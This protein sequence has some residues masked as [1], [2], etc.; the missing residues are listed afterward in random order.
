MEGYRVLGAAT[1]GQAARAMGSEAGIEARTVASLLWRIQAG[2]LRLDESSVLLLDEAGMTDD[3]AML[4]VVEEAEHAR[5]KVVVIGDHRQLSAVGLGGGLEALV[6]R[7]RAAVH[8][9][10]EN[11]RQRDVGEQTA[12][13]QLRSGDVGEAIGWY[14]ANDRVA[15]APTR[16]DALDAVIDR[17]VADVNDA[18][19]TLLLAWR[20]MDVAAL[21]TRARAAWADAGHLTGP[22][23]GAPGGRRYAVGE[24]VVALAP[25]ADGAIVT[26]ERAVI[27][28]VVDG[29][30]D[31]ETGAGRVARLTGQDLDAKHLDHAYAVTVH[32]AQG[33]TVDRAH[34]LAA[35]GGRELA[36]V[37]MSRAR[38]STVVHVVA[39][40][41]DVA[42]DD[43]RREWSSERRDLWILDVDEPSAGGRR[44]PDLAR[45]VHDALRSARLRAEREAVLATLPPD[46]TREILATHLRIGEIETSL[47]HLASGGGAFAGTPVGDAAG[48]L[49]AATHRLR[50]AERVLQAHDL[51]WRTRRRWTHERDEARRAVE[52]ATGAYRT[53]ADPIRITLDDRLGAA[54][55]DLASLERDQTERKTRARTVDVASRLRSIERE[56]SPELA[57]E[58]ESHGVEL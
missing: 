8:V 40:D 41:L 15:I 52:R 57:P 50:S 28:A 38:E 32:R 48:R 44:R 2:T 37:A 7:H 31:V 25:L 19:E 54:R 51:G 42:V 21:N 22:E 33:A 6:G 43:L 30:L 53:L 45:R 47:D 12:L 23:L 56:I 27:T 35:G 13:G 17:W 3:R 5:S 10:D 55:H 26:S 16:D 29:A 9:L 39:D 24:R 4:A 34:L 11:V 46:R 49:T 36:Y 58:I 1:S 20:S 14:V 18:K